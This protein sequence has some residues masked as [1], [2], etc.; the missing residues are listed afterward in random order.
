MKLS[1][2]STDIEIMERYR[3]NVSDRRSYVK[4]TCILMLGKGLSP[5]EVSEYLGIGDSTVYRYK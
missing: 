2:S 1:L 3:R 5:K 4:V